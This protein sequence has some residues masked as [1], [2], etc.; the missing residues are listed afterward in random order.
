MLLYQIYRP[1]SWEEVVGHKNVKMSIKR[2]SE[3]QS[4]G[5]SSFFLTAQSGV[6]KSTIAM[7]IAKEVA[8]EGNIVELD[9]S[10]VTAAAVCELERNWRCL[11]IGEKPG[12]AVIFNECHALR[13]DA[14]RQLLVT[15][16]RLPKHVVVVFTTT[17]EG[18]QSLFDGIDAHPLMSRCIEYRLH[19]NNYTEP[20]AK[21]AK[22]IAEIE[23][24][25][26]APLEDYIDLAKRCKN[27][28]RQM[29]CCIE[30][31][32]LLREEVGV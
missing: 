4:L 12:R 15:L 18:Q 25:G 9:V 1:K 5:G 11:A 31:G 30:A 13:K 17:N 20:F 23:G 16:E 24:L 6:G 32:E 27:N 22:E 19:S 26:G 8:D 10:G 29:L 7:L 3:R 14:V 21:R 2:L 28:L